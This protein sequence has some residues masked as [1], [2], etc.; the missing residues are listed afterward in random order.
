MSIGSICLLTNTFDIV[1]Q[2]Q[3]SPPWAVIAAE[4]H[5]PKKY[6]SFNE[7]T[8]NELVNS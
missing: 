5:K 1:I 2:T 3:S 4:G 6:F 8:F 7:L